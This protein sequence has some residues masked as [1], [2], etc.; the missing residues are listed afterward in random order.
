MIHTAAS[1]DS[2]I[3]RS[4][5]NS[6]AGFRLYC[7]PYAGGGASAY[8]TWPNDLTTEVEVC[9]VQIPGRESRLSEA[10]FTR[11]SL[12]VMALAEALSPQL[13]KPF[14]FFGHSMGAL[15]CFELA[16]ELRRC[17]RPMPDHLFISGHRAPHLPDPS[18]PIHTLP[19]K[20]LVQ[21]LDQLHGTPEV[22]LQHTEL[23]QLIL[24][25]LRS[26]LEM[27]ETY[28]YT[29]QPPLECPIS[30]YG[31]LQD[32]RVSREELVAWHTQ[33]SG[34]FRIQMFPGDHFFIHNC[35]RSLLRA[36]LQQLL[37]K[38]D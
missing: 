12:L 16:R 6:I 31:G 18:H 34:A 9:S 7:F 23:M 33:T 24:P 35:R 15:V 37:D 3:I 5:P 19:E 25:V 30:V 8:T 22:I 10:P 32:P 2:W 13:K 38:G 29:C 1:P 26:D 28:V 27:C 4:R 17:K 11:L 21:E 36:V 20:E 14:A